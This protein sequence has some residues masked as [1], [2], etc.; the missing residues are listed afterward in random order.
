MKVL[1]NIE[2]NFD[3]AKF[4]AGAKIEEAG[5]VEE[6]RRFTETFV[7]L[8]RPKAVY[9]EFFIESFG[10]DSVILGGVTFTSSKLRKNLEG[11]HRVF[12]YIV[13]CGNELEKADLAEF[14]FLAPYWLDRVKEMALREASAFLRKLITEESKFSK[15]VSMNPGSGDVGLWPLSQQRQL[16]SLFPGVTEA[17]GVVLTKSFLM[18]PNK[19]IS[20]ILFPSEESYENCEFCVRLNCPNRRAPT[21]EDYLVKN[22]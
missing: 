14:D 5:L 1:G 6:A 2:W 19:S 15:L 17:I 11:R 12:P 16:F 20:G 7:P 8:L 13:T 3:E 18:V 9:D 10:D 22:T 21:R 4:F